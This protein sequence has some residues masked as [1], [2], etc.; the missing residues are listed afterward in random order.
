MKT[1]EMRINENKENK[2]LNMVAFHE[3]IANLI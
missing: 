3:E 2:I 1:Y